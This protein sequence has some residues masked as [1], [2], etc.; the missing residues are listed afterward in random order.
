MLF[1]E[2]TAD[3][4]HELSSQESRKGSAIEVPVGAKP[5]ERT[6]KNGTING[7]GTIT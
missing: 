1:S 3:I 5:R 6:G 4:L 7:K 2:E